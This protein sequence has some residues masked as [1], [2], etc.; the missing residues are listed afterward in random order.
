MQNIKI[1]LSKQPQ[2]DSIWKG[3]NETTVAVSKKRAPFPI[4]GNYSLQLT[5]VTSTTIIMQIY[6]LHMS[7]KYI[8]VKTNTI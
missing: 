1:Q 3:R 8:N 6:K 5:R 4:N 7:Y 2:H